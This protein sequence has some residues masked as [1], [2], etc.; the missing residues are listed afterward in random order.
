MGYEILISRFDG[1][2]R[3]VIKALI[4]VNPTGR[5]LRV[6]VREVR[7]AIEGLPSKQRAAV[8]MHKYQELEY[9]QIAKTLSCSESA[10]KSLLFR[11]YETLRARLSHMA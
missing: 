5:P 1:E 10:V 7:N 9:S 2:Q 3:V 6:G 4:R 8:F 11:A